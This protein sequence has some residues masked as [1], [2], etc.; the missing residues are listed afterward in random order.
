MIILLISFAFSVVRLSGKC[1]FV[2]GA[3]LMG[4]SQDGPPQ[5][6]LGCA[7]KSEGEFFIPVS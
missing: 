5:Y 6:I 4:V 3:K 7:V 2:W 1:D